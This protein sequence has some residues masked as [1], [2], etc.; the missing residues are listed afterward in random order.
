M[1]G[2]RPRREAMEQEPAAENMMR[3]RIAQLEQAK[4]A[5]EQFA[6]HA[7]QL[8]P[9]LARQLT[10]VIEQTER[11]A[12]DLTG[13]IRSISERARRQAAEDRKSVV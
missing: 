10:T 12:M 9:V 6:S 8:M 5:W 3:E 2:T 11:A 4:H 13:K 7:V 1:N